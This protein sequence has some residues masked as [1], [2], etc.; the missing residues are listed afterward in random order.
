MSGFSNINTNLLARTNMAMV[1]TACMPMA[2]NDKISRHIGVLLFAED[3]TRYMSAIGALQYL[4]L[5]I[6]D[7]YFSVRASTMLGA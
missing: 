1:K 7:I 6:P 4:T 2:T 5:T 3:A